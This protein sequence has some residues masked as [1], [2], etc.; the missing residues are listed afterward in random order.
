MPKYSIVTPVYNSF[1]LMTRYFQSF[2]NQTY[3]DFELVIVDDCSTDDSYEALLEYSRRTTLNVKILRTD[4]NAGP[5][6]ARN[7][8]IDN[9]VGDWITFVDNDDWVS[10]DFL[11]EIDGIASIQDIDCVVFDYFTWKDGQLSEGDSLYCGENGNISVSEC[12]SFLRNHAVC[13]AYKR[14]RISTLRYPELKRCEDVAFV[15]L[16]VSQCSRVYYL[17]KPLYYYYQRKGSLSNNSKLD[18]TDLIS[19]FSIVE[20]KLSGK[21]SDE[22]KEKSVP[23]LLYGVL[24]MMGKSN[25]TNRE[26]KNYIINYEKH[27]NNWWNCRV[28][29]YL[30]KP[31][32]LFLFFARIHF[33]SGIKVLARIHGAMIS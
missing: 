21:Y 8:G 31:K 10:N 33:S 15:P 1:D 11:Y 17:K 23:D 14:Q 6:N 24:L 2:E 9:A 3:K 4:L 20:K 27:Y 18:E 25:K 16:A 12:I 26:I 32:R 28:I 5:G 30:G 22:L 13:K 19:A 7:K 29:K